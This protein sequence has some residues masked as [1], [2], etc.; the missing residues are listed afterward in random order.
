MSPDSVQISQ[1]AMRIMER[2]VREAAPLEACGLVGGP[3][4]R[5]QL[6]LPV[7]NAAASPTR[8]RMAPQ[9]QL[10]ALFSLE[11]RGLELVAIYHSHPA[12]PVMPSATDLEEAAYPE[13]A[14]LIWAPDATGWSCR[15][16]ALREG[17]FQLVPLE[18]VG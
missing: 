9:G 6:V 18:V 2:Q 1:T 5:G 8:F 16:F 13:A 3:P 15:A 11:R 10:D 14:Y 7:E 12:G 17:Q 4:G